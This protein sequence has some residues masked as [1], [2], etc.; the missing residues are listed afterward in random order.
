MVSSNDWNFIGENI[1]TQGKKVLC[2]LSYMY[3]YSIFSLI[4]AK[5]VGQ[6]YVK[7]ISTKNTGAS[8]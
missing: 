2:G 3:N 5:S 4:Q 7:V 6:K 1:T 8:K